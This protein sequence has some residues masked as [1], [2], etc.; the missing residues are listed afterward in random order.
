VPVGR[1]KEDADPNQWRLDLTGYAERSGVLSVL[2]LVAENSDIRTLSTDV[3]PSLCPST[4][5]DEPAPK[6]TGH[7]RAVRIR[8][9]QPPGACTQLATV[10][11]YINESDEIVG[12]N[13]GLGAP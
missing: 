12:V 4:L 1:S 7:G 5:L 13:V 8:I 10:D 3:R 2:D 11:L 9:L 6:L